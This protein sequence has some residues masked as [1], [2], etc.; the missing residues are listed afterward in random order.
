MGRSGCSAAKDNSSLII[1]DDNFNTI[2][3]AIKWGSNI[4]ENCKKFLQFQLTCNI[5]CVMTVLIGSA[6]VGASPFTVMQLLWI[7]L[8]MDILGAIALAT[9]APKNNTLHHRDFTQDNKEITPTMRL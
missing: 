5:S 1:L 7:N 9:E 4:F 6:S 8:I 3:N 2:Y